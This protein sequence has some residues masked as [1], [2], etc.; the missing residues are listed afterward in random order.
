MTVIK[1]MLNEESESIIWNAIV[2]ISGDIVYGGRVTDDIDR[3][4]LM[5]ILTTFLGEDVLV[6]GYKYS[7]SGVY[8]P[9][10]GEE[11]TLESLIKKARGLP[12]VDNPEIFGMNENADIAFQLQESNQMIDIVLSVQPRTSSGAAGGK[13]PDQIIDELAQKIEGEMPELLTRDG[14][15]KELFHA[16]K[17]GLLPSLSTFLLQ[18][19]ERFNRL[20]VIIQKSLDTLRKAIKGLAVMSEDVDRMYKSM[21]NNKVPELWAD[22]AYPSLNPLSSWIQNFKERIEFLRMWLLKGKPAA[23]WMPAFFFP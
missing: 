2:Q 1:G 21:L 5:M 23:Y 8:R 6:P 16:S 22:N 9:P 17:D 15:N 4:T 12:D 20:V 18:E 14:A 7:Q 19:M 11:T 3:R 13:N 10:T